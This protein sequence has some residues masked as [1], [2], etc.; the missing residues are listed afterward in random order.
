MNPDITSQIASEKRNLATLKAELMGSLTKLTTEIATLVESYENEA[1]VIIMRMMHLKSVESVLSSLSESPISNFDGNE[2]LISPKTVTVAPA[3]QRG[4]MT[5]TEFILDLLER[6]SPIAARDIDEAVI[7]SGWS[8][9]ASDKAR[10]GLKK[11]GFATAEKRMWS[12]TDKGKE[13]T[14]IVT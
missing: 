5:V 2:A 13:K 9:A 6:S 4:T 3:K 12:I 8:K 10:V 14:M 1:T 7:A 11:D